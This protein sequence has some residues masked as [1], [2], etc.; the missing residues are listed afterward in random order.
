[1]PVIV[2]AETRQMSAEE[3][4]DVAYNVMRHVFAVHAEFGRCFREVVYQREIAHRC[5]GRFEVPV[6]VVHD[7]FRKNDYLDLLVGGGAVFEVKTAE[8]LTEK[9]R[10]QLMH[11]LLLAQIP[12][13]KLVNLRPA[14]VEQEF[15]NARLTHAERTVF[16]IDDQAWERAAPG[17]E[18]LHERTV[19]LLLDLGTGLSVSLYQEAL[20][21]F[22]GGEQ[23]VIQ[24]VPVFSGGRQVGSQPLG[25]AT[26]ESAFRVTT[27]NEDVRSKWQPH[28]ARMLSHTALGF[29]HWINIH[30]GA[31]TLATLRRK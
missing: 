13:G 7:T 11:Y 5:G 17:A 6:E 16:M 9:H 29:L 20:V 2:H 30:R 12:R 1:M 21:H 31:L 25:M 8:M 23:S 27:L 19:S 18:Q 28:L 3:F 26:P 22:L 4:K 14:S 15:V 10:N 24:D